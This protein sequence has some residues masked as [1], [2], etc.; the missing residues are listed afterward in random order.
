MNK[1]V[2]EEVEEEADLIQQAIEACGRSK[3][4]YG[5]VGNH[6]V[7]LELFFD[8]KEYTWK[9]KVAVDF[10][11]FAEKDVGSNYRDACNI[12]RR[13]AKKY[14]LSVTEIARATGGGIYS[15]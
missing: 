3:Y 10:G 15:I 1:K 14:K 7:S 8:T 11:Y 5:R 9:I 13:Y 4:A 6:N 2:K 12:F